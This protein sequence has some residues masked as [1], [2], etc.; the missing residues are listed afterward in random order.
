MHQRMLLESKS[1]SINSMIAYIV[2]GNDP[3]QDPERR[4]EFYALMH[5]E[6]F[7]FLVGEIGTDLAQSLL[8]REE[9][10]HDNTNEM[11]EMADGHTA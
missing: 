9:D 4:D 1:A 10:L 5:E 11:K 8:I 6:E 7:R 3:R 2:A